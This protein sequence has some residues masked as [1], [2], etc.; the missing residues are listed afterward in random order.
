MHEIATVPPR[1]AQ[2]RRSVA[3]EDVERVAQ[4]LLGALVVREPPWRPR[5][6]AVGV[7]VLDV[8]AL[9]EAMLAAGAAE[10]RS[11]D[12]APRRLT[13]A[14]RVPEVVRPDHPGLEPARDAPRPL[15]VARPHTRRK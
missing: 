12:A 5:P 10:A 6:A 1:V 14:E 3:V 9:V 8:H 15:G 13:R 7:D 11:L 4:G 2:P